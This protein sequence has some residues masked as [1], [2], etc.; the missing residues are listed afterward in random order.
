MKNSTS[1]KLATIIEWVSIKSNIQNKEKFKQLSKE[2]KS[3][4]V[5]KRILADLLTPI[6][7]YMKLA[8]GAKYSFILESVEKGEK[9]G[10]Y[11]FIGRNPISVI[12]SENNK[13]YIPEYSNLE[14]KIS[15]TGHPDHFICCGY[16][17]PDRFSNIGFTRF[18]TISVKNLSEE[19]ISRFNLSTDHIAWTY[20]K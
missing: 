16:D 8:K 20:I 2:Y 14:D 18:K 11:S 9:Y 4:P 15:K 7:A 6:S 13:T 10:R 5:Y 12:K 17:Y 1:A 3:V 19:I